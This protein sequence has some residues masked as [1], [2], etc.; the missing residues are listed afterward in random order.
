MKKSSANLD[1]LP[2]KSRAG[3]FGRYHS[4]NS[5]NYEHDR[6]SNVLAALAPGPSTNDRGFNSEIYLLVDLNRIMNAFFQLVP[7]PNYQPPQTIKV[8]EEL[9]F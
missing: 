3:L 2:I 1:T 8:I 6:I 7:N 5:V 9:Y 4:Q